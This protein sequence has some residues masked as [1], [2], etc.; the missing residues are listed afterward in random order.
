MGVS[1]SGSSFTGV[2]SKGGGNLGFLAGSLDPRGFSGSGSLWWQA[3]A[4]AAPLRCSGI[5][6]FAPLS[7]ATC[8][9]V[10]SQQALGYLK[11]GESRGQATLLSPHSRRRKQI[12]ETKAGLSIRGLHL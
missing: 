4:T 12:T 6:S 9:V 8:L 2:T 10:S 3:L 5:S 7:P 11:V 1:E